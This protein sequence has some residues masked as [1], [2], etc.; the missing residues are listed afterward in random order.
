[1]ML[2][3]FGVRRRQLL[4]IV[5]PTV[6]SLKCVDELLPLR[7]ESLRAGTYGGTLVHNA[8]TSQQSIERLRLR[9]SSLKLPCL[10][11]PLCDVLSRLRGLEEL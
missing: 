2:G 7:R 6:Q 5:P 8:D 10:L 11:R 4:Q 3:P 1:M 9:V